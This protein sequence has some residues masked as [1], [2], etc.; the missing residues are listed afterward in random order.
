MRRFIVCTLAAGMLAASSA[1][2]AVTLRY[3]T[4]YTAQ[5]NVV[6]DALKPYFNAVREK[7][8]GKLDFRIFTD[9]TV[10]TGDT[11]VPGITTGIV[12]AGTIVPTYTPAEL[13]ISATLVRLPPIPIDALADAGAISEF[14]FRQCGQCMEEYKRQDITPLAFYASTPYYLQCKK[15]LT[16]ESTLAGWKL[17]TTGAW[18][19]W[20]GAIGAAP[21]NT[22]AGEI[23]TALSQ[24]TVDCTASPLT[25]LKTFGLQS[26]VTTVLDLPLGT[27]RPV[28]VLAINTSV[29]AKLSEDEKAAL[30]DAL[31]ELVANTAWSYEEEQS[32]VREE[33]IKAGIKYVLPGK[34]LSE[35]NARYV[36]ETKAAVIAA[37]TKAGL[38]NSA[39]QV[40]TY[41]KTAEEWKTLMA[42]KPSKDE[43]VELLREKIYK[44]LAF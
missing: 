37:L 42:K 19:R 44:G 17:R 28:A 39:E 9:G 22:T 23:Y 36:D 35:N 12:D 30:L 33:S 10:V 4:Y 21:V 14:M 18:D 13:P 6:V 40:D 38:E 7:S 32:E 3:G 20:A 24:R 41:L 26:A 5:H 15:E 27:Y 2:G 11:I 8:G 29:L 43:Y 16:P 34:T 25:Y 31:P 1:G